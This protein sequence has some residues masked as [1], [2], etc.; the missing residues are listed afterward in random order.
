MF[1]RKK[2]L[3]PTELEK[4]INRLH[5]DLQT[6]DPHTEQY[7]KTVQNLA[8][9]MAMREHDRVSSYRPSPDVVL[10]CLVSL[11][12]IGIIVRHEDVNVM[13]SKAIGFVKKLG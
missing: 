5:D 13:T 4:A 2:T 9:L 10:T 8:K 11:L 3:E 12:Q 1:A 7:T 6:Y